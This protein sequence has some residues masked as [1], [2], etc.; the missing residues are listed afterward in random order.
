M[1]PKHLE[2]HNASSKLFL[3]LGEQT[4]ILVAS[5][6]GFSK[7]LPSWKSVENVQIDKNLFLKLAFIVNL[8]THG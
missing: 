6:R 4:V 1:F 7:Q 8:Y 3:K 2:I 5:R